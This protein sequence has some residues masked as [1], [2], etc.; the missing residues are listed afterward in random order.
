MHNNHT[1]VKA[2]EFLRSF[3]KKNGRVLFLKTPIAYDK[4]IKIVL[5]CYKYAGFLFRNIP[6]Y[7]NWK[8]S[9][10]GRY[11]NEKIV[12]YVNENNYDLDFLVKNTRFNNSN[13]PLVSIVIPT[14]GNALMTLRCLYSICKNSPDCEYEVIVI[15]DFSGDTEIDIL[16]NIPGLIFSKNSRNLGFLKS[17]NAAADLARGEYFYLLNN[18]T[19]VTDGWLTNLLDVFKKD[20]LCGLVGS[21]LVYPDGR[22][23]EAGG[24]MWKD[25]SAWNFGR[26]S[27]PSAPSFN[28]L[29]EVDYCSGASF[30]VPLALFNQLGRF[31]ELYVPAYCEDSDF[32]FSVRKAGYKVMY[33]PLS[34]VVHFEG[35]SHG[36]DTGSGIK[37]Y[38]IENQKKFKQKWSDELAYHSNNAEDVFWAR[39]RSHDKK[40]ILIVEHYVPQ[41]DKDAG[42]R[43]MLHM[44]K[45]F[46][47]QGLNVKFWPQNLW[48]DP[49]YTTQ[50]Q[51]LGVEVIYGSD[52][53][54]CFERWFS[55]HSKYIDFVLLSRPYVAIEYINTIRA[56]SQ[57]TLLYYG[58]DIHHLRVKEQMKIE[59]DSAALNKEYETLYNME[60]KVWSLVDVIYYPSPS[61]T[62]VVLDFIQQNNP[63]A[64]ALTTPMNAFSDFIHDAA[65]NLTSRKNIIFVGGFGH[66]PNQDGVFWFV[67]N[68]WPLV[69]AVNKDI[70]LFL[71]GSNPTENIK[72]L[73]SDDI[74]VT[75]FVTDEHLELFYKD[76]RL[77]IAP[78]L[79]GAGVKG[80]VVE[81]MRFGLPVVTT[82]VGAQGLSSDPNILIAEDEPSAFAQQVI[83]LLNDDMKWRNISFNQTVYVKQNFSEQAMQNAFSQLFNNGKNYED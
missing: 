62:D 9:K 63:S 40:T 51:S 11:F 69:K 22:L 59:G 1:L 60:R 61:E 57:A 55:E 70:K 48:Y 39:D 64:K 30:M 50:L 75:G 2:K 42:S 47:A 14:Y 77:A 44:I 38:Q 19:L 53:V 29:K 25:G 7:E 28:Y 23:Q 78:L 71:V 79:Y 32:S 3:I 80:K 46:L 82:S 15:E 17:C 41:P 18:D 72:Q 24:I 43:T 67:Q 8:N 34:V 4:K 73:A 12:K 66:K 5:L 36:T 31:D 37:S 52:Y 27:D 65:E 45:I 20:K 16:E 83:E 76:A 49:I 10:D 6:H 26:L 33:Q 21:K 54:G 81:S 58:H 13:K 56:H 68:V 74:V 35:I